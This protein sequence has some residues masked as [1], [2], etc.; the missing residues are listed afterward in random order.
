M[1]EFLLKKYASIEKIDTIHQGSVLS[2]TSF[3]FFEVH[4]S[5]F[6]NVHKVQFHFK[7][8]V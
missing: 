6:L 5:V 1:I 4:I 3:V 8:S 7:V 2:Q